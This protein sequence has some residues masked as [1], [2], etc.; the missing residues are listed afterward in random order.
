MG[1]ISLITDL[2]NMLW[3]TRLCNP[4]LYRILLSLAADYRSSR[5]KMEYPSTEPPISRLEPQNYSRLEL[6]V[7]ILLQVITK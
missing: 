6:T 1:G 3:N 7:A 5:L 2:I 4:R